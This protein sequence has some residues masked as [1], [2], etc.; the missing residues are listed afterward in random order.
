MIVELCNCSLKIGYIGT[1]AEIMFDQM[2]NS[3]DNA[4]DAM[5]SFCDALNRAIDQ[6]IPK[7]SRR[8]KNIERIAQEA[9]RKQRFAK[10]GSWK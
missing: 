5:R 1:E 9:E 3:L 7:K 10:G 6:I 4:I 8:H 2:A